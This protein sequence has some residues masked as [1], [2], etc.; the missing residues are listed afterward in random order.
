MMLLGVL[1]EYGWRQR[2][3][4]DEQHGFCLLGA[5]RKAGNGKGYTKNTYNNIFQKIYDHKGGTLSFN[6]HKDTTKEMVIET[7]KWVERN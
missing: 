7:L 6:D 5:I 2:L 3:L 4:G 1:E